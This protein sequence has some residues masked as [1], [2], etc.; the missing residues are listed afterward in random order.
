MVVD[1]RYPATGGAEMQ[2]RLLSRSFASAGHEVRVLVP[3]LDRSLPFT[4]KVDGI[5][6]LRLGYPKIKGLGA[7]LLN[8]NFAL[9]LL[10]HQGEFDAIHIHMMHNL[11]GAA[12]WINRW[13]KPTLIVKV[14]GAAEFQGGILDPKLMTKPVHRIL[15][16]GA[17]HLD[18]YQCISK[19]TVKIMLEAGF[20][21]E[22]LHLLP[23]AVD[24][25]R[26]AYKETRVQSSLRA[27]FVGRHVP[28]KG[29]DVLLESWV[30][31]SL[32]SP[33]AH[34]TLAG[35][36]PERERLM[37]LSRQLGIENSVSFPG[38]VQDVPALL[39]SHNLYVQASHQEGLPN[40]VLEAMA[41][42]LP[43]VATQISGHEDVIAHSETGL[44]VPPNHADELA[45]AISH[46]AENPNLRQ[47]MGA[48][49]RR[50]VEQYFSTEAVMQSLLA[51]YTQPSAPLS[52]P[53]TKAKIN[54]NR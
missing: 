42:G 36:G 23:N 19:K 30:R 21:K 47:E 8:L 18:A 5:P 20:A 51:V 53:M 41:N 39:S 54:A 45:A 27:V 35:D 12:G 49:A 38:L 10:R 50:F 7:I 52:H 29:L 16:R 14:S 24:L 43:T 44:L 15:R 28:V 46:L 11:A 25:V 26:F 13:L 6:V 32:Q 4:D 2:A 22:R 40:A 37:T 1:G 9:W 48:T 33:D 3:H 31:V 34:L 17:Q